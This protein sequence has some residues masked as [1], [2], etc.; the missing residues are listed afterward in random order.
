MFRKPESPLPIFVK[1]ICGAFESFDY[2]KYIFQVSAM[3]WYSGA[4]AGKC[5]RIYLL[6]YFFLSLFSILVIALPSTAHISVAQHFVYVCLHKYWI[7][8]WYLFTLLWHLL[9]FF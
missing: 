9:W 1:L 4:V 5:N 6:S 3:S 8:I 7:P 2:V